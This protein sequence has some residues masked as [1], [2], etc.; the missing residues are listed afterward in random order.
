M[1][2]FDYTDL[3]NIFVGRPAA[4]IVRFEHCRQL[5][6]Q[7]L[8]RPRRVVKLSVQARTSPVTGDCSC[9]LLPRPRRVVK[10]FVQ[11]TGD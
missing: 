9:Q 5:L 1:A 7:L 8:P 2:S 10:L 4:N 3:L 6:C 11:L